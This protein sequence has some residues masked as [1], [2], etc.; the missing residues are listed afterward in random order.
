MAS[1]FSAP[2]RKGDA[3][4]FVGLTSSFP[5][6]TDSGS[7][8]L[9]ESRPCAGQDSAVPGCKVFHVPAADSSQARQIEGDSV[10]R[11][12]GGLRDQVLVFKYKGKV[13]AINNRCPH[14]SYP[15]SEGTPFDIEDFGVALSAGISC[16]KHGWSFDL[17]SG[18]ADRANYKLGIWE[19]Q[20]RPNSGTQA[21][22]GDEKDEDDQ[23]V[24][25]RRKQRMG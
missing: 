13:H 14:S 15:L 22:A 7:A 25:V 16:P 4:F 1:P 11:P 20:L 6:I 10:F 2:S 9:S 3:W 21:A 17:F 8:V 5:D 18:R 19:V 24:W 23:E 12:E